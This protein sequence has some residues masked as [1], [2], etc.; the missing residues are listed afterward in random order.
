MMLWVP[1]CVNG[2]ARII[3]T[4]TSCVNGVARIIVTTAIPRCLLD[5]DWSHGGKGLV[6]GGT[7]DQRECIP[8]AI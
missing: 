5:V 1:S 3:V 8:P 6:K 4:T 7:M 2:V